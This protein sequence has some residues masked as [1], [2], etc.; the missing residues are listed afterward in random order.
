M[1]TKRTKYTKFTGPGEFPTQSQWR[2]ALMFSLIC[3][4]INGWTNN[5]ET[6]DLRRH[7]GHYDVIVIKLNDNYT[8]HNA[9][10]AGGD[11]H[12]TICNFILNLLTLEVTKFYFLFYQVL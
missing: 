7:R 2:G 3:V 5:R 6:G 9:T 11:Q 8:G 12:I 4:W 10:I 1:Y